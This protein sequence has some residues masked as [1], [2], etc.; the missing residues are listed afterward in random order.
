MRGPPLLPANRCGPVARVRACWR[1]GLSRDANRPVNTS[2]TPRQLVCFAASPAKINGPVCSLKL[3]ANAEPSK[4]LVAGTERPCLANWRRLAVMGLG[5]ETV[6]TSPPSGSS[7]ICHS[8]ADI[9]TQNKN[10]GRF[11]LRKSSKPN[12]RP[13][14]FYV[15]YPQ[16]GTVP[17]PSSRRICC[18]PNPLGAPPNEPPA[19]SLLD[20]NGGSRRLFR[21]PARLGNLPSKF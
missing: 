20:R 13:H 6:A 16:A 3:S 11:Q 17:L 18:L 4:G 5:V 8:E 19:I 12:A 10:A 14:T 15:P 9:E 21:S 7:N 2:Q 1:P